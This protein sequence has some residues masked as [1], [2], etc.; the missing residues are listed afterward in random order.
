MTIP[1]YLDPDTWLRNVFSAKA[2]GRGGVIH[3]SARDVERIVGRDAFLREVQRRGFTLVENGDQLVVFC[4]RDPVRLIVQRD[5]P[6]LSQRAWPMGRD[7]H[8]R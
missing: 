2:V 1:D 4:N 6:S 8:I 7:A 5:P 3:R